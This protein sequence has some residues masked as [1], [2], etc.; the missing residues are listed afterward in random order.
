MAQLKLANMELSIKAQKAST[1]RWTLAFDTELQGENLD[2]LARIRRLPEVG[3]YQ[4]PHADIDRPLHLAKLN[5][6]WSAPVRGADQASSTVKY[7][8]LMPALHVSI[9]T[10]L[11]GIP[12]SGC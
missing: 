7:Q 9:K 1:C 2:T 12:L 4:L 10:K 6:S 3:P 5:G 8:E 11:D